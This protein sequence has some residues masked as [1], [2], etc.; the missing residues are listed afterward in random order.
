MVWHL[1]CGLNPHT[2]IALDSVLDRIQSVIDNSCVL[3]VS[4]LAVGTRKGRRFDLHSRRA[5]CPAYAV[6]LTRDNI[7]IQT[8][9]A[10]VLHERRPVTTD[11]GTAWRAPSAL[12][13]R[14]GWGYSKTS[15]SWT[16]CTSVA[17]STS[18]SSGWKLARR[19]SS[20]IDSDCADFVGTQRLV[21]ASSDTIGKQNLRRCDAQ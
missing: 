9:E 20:V 19:H 1:K 17:Q 3:R 18:A 15:I 13:Q 6:R 10:N 16:H 5:L 21:S 11:M 7:V 12:R 4:D 2:L 8:H 14:C